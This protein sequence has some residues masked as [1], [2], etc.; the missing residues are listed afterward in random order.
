VD[1][2]GDGV[3]ER[4]LVSEGDTVAPGAELLRIVNPAAQAESA[5]FSAEAARFAGRGRAARQ[6][7]DATAAA[8]A[9]GG[10]RAAAAGLEK[11]VVE[12]DRLSIKSPIAGRVLTARPADLVGDFVTAGTPLLEVADCAKLTAELPVSER[13]LDDLAVGAPVRALLG[14]RPTRPVRG[15]IVRISPATL[16]QPVTARGLKDP[17][18][19]S[20]RP[21]RFVA[22]AVFENP[23]GTLRPGDVARAKIYAARASVLSR[24]WRVLRRWLQTIV[25]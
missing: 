15:Q 21:D 1:A 20:M 13:L 17:P 4:V 19:P 14:Q 23:D 12:Q 24:G 10:R 3:V 5:R 7:G 11:A 2:P 18:R 25:W 6:A 9:D 16:D 8:E 22:L